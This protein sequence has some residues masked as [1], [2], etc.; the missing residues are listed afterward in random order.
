MTLSPSTV[1]TSP[2][3]ASQIPQKVFLCSIIAVPVLSFAI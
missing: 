2:H 3:D 1:A